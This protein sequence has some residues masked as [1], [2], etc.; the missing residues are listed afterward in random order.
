MFCSKCGAQ[1]PEGTLFCTSCGQPVGGLPAPAAVSPAY[2]SPG[3]EPAASIPVYQSAPAAVPLPSPYAGF[4]LRVVA[5]II[6]GITLGVCWGAHVGGRRI[7]R[8]WCSAQRNRR[9]EQFR[10]RAIGRLGADAHLRRVYRN[11]CVVDLQRLHGKLAKS[12]NAGENGAR[13]DRH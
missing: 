2:T 10:C 13:V 7:H 4:W 9:N 6:D 8:R 1:L 5:H 11:S 12:R 3:I